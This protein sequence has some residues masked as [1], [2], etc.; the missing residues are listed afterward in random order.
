MEE[1]NEMVEFKAGAVLFRE[2]DPAGYMLVIRSGQIEIFINGKDNQKLPLSI[3][4]SGEF[5]GELSILAGKGRTATAIALTDVSAIKITKQ[6]FEA[7][8]KNLPFWMTGLMTCLT[9][10]IQRINELI[11]RNGL[12]DDTLMTQIEAAESN[13]LPKK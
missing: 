5:L 2:G 12:V 3:I 4:N 13:L 10:R 11:R 1:K 7:Q 8:T 6:T 9:T